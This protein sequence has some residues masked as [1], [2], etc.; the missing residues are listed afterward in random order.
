VFVKKEQF[1]KYLTL[2]DDKK[3]IEKYDKQLV[4]YFNNAGK[5]GY[6]YSQDEPGFMEALTK[7]VA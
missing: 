3:Y 2:N 5:P 6:D 4:G 1:D 7:K